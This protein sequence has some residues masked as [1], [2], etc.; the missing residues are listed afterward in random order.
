MKWPIH[1]Q[2]SNAPLFVRVRRGAVM[3]VPGRR[4]FFCC[5]LLLFAAL[6]YLPVAERKRGERLGFDTFSAKLELWLWQQQDPCTGTFQ[7]SLILGKR[8]NNV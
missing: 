3:S 7:I 4:V 1:Q 5:C 2:P 6:G 8:I